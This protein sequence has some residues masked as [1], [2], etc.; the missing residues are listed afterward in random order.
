MLKKSVVVAL[1]GLLILGL[2]SVAIAAPGGMWRGNSNRASVN[3]GNVRP[4]ITQLNLSDEQYNK[5]QAIHNNYF[6]K[7]QSMRN[8]IFTKV[9]E[10]RNLILQKN[11]DEKAIEAKQKEVDEIRSQMADLKQKKSDEINKVL[12]EEQLEKL[13]SLRGSGR[14]AGSGMGMGKGVGRGRGICGS[15]GLN[16]NL[17]K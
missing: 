7:L 10:I 8:D 15:C 3:N 17:N 9:S 11:P 16:T 5:I 13:N 12:T 6:E 2:A 4:L 14:G 1:V